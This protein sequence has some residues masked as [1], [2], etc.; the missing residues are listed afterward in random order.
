MS[1][2]LTGF[3]ELHGGAPGVE[4]QYERVPLVDFA[5]QQ[6]Q[7]RLPPARQRPL[8]HRNRR[9]RAARRRPSLNIKQPQQLRPRK[10]P[11]RLHSPACAACAR[12]A[13]A[14]AAC[15]RAAV[16]RARRAGQREEVAAESRGERLG[17]GQQPD[18]GG[19]RLRE[20]N[21]RSPPQR[22]PVG[23][24]RARE[25]Q[26]EA[27]ERSHVRA[28]EHTVLLAP[29]DQ[30]LEHRE[31]GEL[32]TFGRRSA[33]RKAAGFSRTPLRTRG[34][35][36]RLEGEGP[37][38]RAAA[39]RIRGAHRVPRAHNRL[40]HWRE[41]PWAQQRAPRELQRCARRAPPR[42]R[43]R[44]GVQRGTGPPRIK[45]RARARAAGGAPTTV[46][47]RMASSPAGASA[48][49]TRS[50]PTSR[51]PRAP[52]GSPPHTAA[53]RAG[54]SSSGSATLACR[55]PALRS[56]GG[57]LGGAAEER[58]AA[59]RNVKLLTCWSPPAPFGSASCSA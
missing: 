39:G 34:A 31:L 11:K 55:R 40:V 58:A 18:R 1:R 27:A 22:G 56:G 13:C 32:R 26:D 6:Q 3:L 4:R 21:E 10:L 59:C 36:R 45:L 54:I 15:A 38:A 14:R 17:G 37:G 12:A 43:P 5:V 20:R 23:A 33:C 28:E 35:G 57:T 16:R 24:A 8:C 30:P 2:T 7:V 29:K 51:S 41:V 25:A 48:S 42:K 52:D 19:G 49:R 50:P 46:S 9:T 47:E 53:Y 44:G